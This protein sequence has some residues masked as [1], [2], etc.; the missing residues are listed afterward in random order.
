MSLDG[1]SLWIPRLHVDNNTWTLLRNLMALEEHRDA[2]PAT[3]Y[4]LFMSQLACTAEDVELLR[5]T[6][7]IEHFL[8]TDKSATKGFAGLCHSVVLDI[9]DPQRN[10]LK[11]IWHRL[12]KRYGVRQE[13]RLDNC[14]SIV[15]YLLLYFVLV[16]GCQ[17]TESFY[18]VKS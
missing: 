7:V 9:D 11:P 4:F 8:G 12:E 5:S 2:R 18:A 13:H 3:A 16:L 15:F 1:G 17:V 6:K 14:C 10:Y